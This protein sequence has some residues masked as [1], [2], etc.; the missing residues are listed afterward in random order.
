MVLQFACTTNKNYVIEY[1]SDLRGGTWTP[2][3]SPVFT[4][5]GPGIGQWVDDGTLTDGLKVPFRWY[6]VRLKLSGPP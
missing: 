3:P 4:W 5:P 6:R 1:A 2:V